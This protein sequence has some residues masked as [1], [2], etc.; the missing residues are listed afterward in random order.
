MTEYL[1]K[2]RELPIHGVTAA[3]LGVGMVEAFLFSISVV[4]KTRA[5][6]KPIH[7]RI[8][9]CRS[10]GH[11]L[12]S[13]TVFMGFNWL[14]FTRSYSCWWESAEGISALRNRVSHIWWQSDKGNSAVR[15]C[16]L[17]CGWA[18]DDGISALSNH[19]F[20][21]RWKSDE[22]IPALRNRISN[23]GWESDV[24]ISALR[25]P[26]FNRWCEFVERDFA[27]RNRVSTGLNVGPMALGGR[28][29]GYVFGRT[30]EFTFTWCYRNS[31]GCWHGRSI[32]L[33]TW[34]LRPAFKEGY[35]QVIRQRG[36]LCCLFLCQHLFAMLLSTVTT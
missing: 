3:Q 6:C 4:C 33:R 28:C 30:L 18:S 17:N 16:V 36:Y 22:G 15:N 10:F 34:L 25:S 7:G 23:S 27:R 12:C 9:P 29:R 20:D 35:T 26:A 2:L 24:G 31:I 19:F 1:G 32:F 21:G 5:N 14:C 13:W 8:G 11:E